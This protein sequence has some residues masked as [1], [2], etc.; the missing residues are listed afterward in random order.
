MLSVFDLTFNRPIRR[1][2]TVYTAHDRAARDYVESHLGVRKGRVRVI[3]IGTDTD[4]FRYRTGGQHLK[5]GEVQ[6]PDR[7]T[8]APYKGLDHLIRAMDIV[9]KKD[10]G[11][12][13]YIK[14]NGRRRR[15]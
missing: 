5:D 13:L 10:D 2:A 14:G 8:P 12:V 6:S 7:R 11:I 4:F 15:S 3:P 1:G 9:H